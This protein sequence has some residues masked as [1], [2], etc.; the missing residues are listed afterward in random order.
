M[1]RRQP[2]GA[3]AL[4]VSRCRSKGYRFAPHGIDDAWLAWLIEDRQRARER[5][6]ERVAR[7]PAPVAGAEVPATR[8][9]GYGHRYDRFTAWGVAAE[10]SSGA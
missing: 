9:S 2:R 5:A 3:H 6:Q 4:F 8:P 1:P 10:R 7:H